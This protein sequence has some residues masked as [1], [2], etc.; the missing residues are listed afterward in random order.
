[1]LIIVTGGNR[2]F[3]RRT[4]SSGIADGKKFGIQRTSA[5]AG[6]LTL[7]PQFLLKTF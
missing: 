1:M 7:L 2:Y 3:R 4:R 5:T 6:D